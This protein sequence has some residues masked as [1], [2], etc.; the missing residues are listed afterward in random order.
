[1]KKKILGNDD[2]QI[3][4]KMGSDSAEEMKA[5]K[6]L[7]APKRKP[8][9][10]GARKVE[11]LQQVNMVKTANKLVGLVENTNLYDSDERIADQ[12][13]GLDTVEENLLGRELEL[14]LGHKDPDQEKQDSGESKKDKASGFMDKMKTKR[15]LQQQSMGIESQVVDLGFVQNL[16]QRVSANELA[17]KG[18]QIS[19]RDQLIKFLSQMDQ[20]DITLKQQNLL[21]VLQNEQTVTPVPSSV[22][23]EGTH[24]T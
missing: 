24:Q 16:A 15:Q 2:E 7:K 18:I 3:S 19:I 11:G 13:L 1:M 23:G 22:P 9:V 20:S 6:K 4:D 10:S 5:G 21:N 12:G 17:A 14:D 8:K